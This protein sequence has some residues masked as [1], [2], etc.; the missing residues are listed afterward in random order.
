MRN[1]NKS[2]VYLDQLAAL[3]VD[4][5]IIHSIEGG[6][7]LASVVLGIHTLRV[8]ELPKTPLCRRK[9]SEMRRL[10]A[11]APCDKVFLLQGSPYDE[12]VGSQ[13][14]VANTLRIPLTPYREVLH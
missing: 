1:K 12:M 2:V 8:Y 5:V 9:M 7:Y 3:P 11:S 6:M 14:A 4:E 10:L 13:S